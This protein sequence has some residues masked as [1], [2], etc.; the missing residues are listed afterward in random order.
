ML[1]EG[2]YTFNILGVKWLGGGK[3]DWYFNSTLV[4]AGQDWYSADPVPNV[5]QTFTITVGVTEG[6]RHVLVGVVNG[7]NGASGG[8]SIRLTKMWAIPDSDN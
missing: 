4:C 5:T 8:Y 3:I 7:K 2:V 6:G 1:A